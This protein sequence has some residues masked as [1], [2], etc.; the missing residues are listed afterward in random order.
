[1]NLDS[2]TPPPQGGWRRYL[3]L[4]IYGLVKYLPTP[5]GDLLRWAVAKPFLRRLDTHWIHEGVTFHNPE[6]IS[7]G[8]S[9]LNEFVFING[10]GGVTIGDRCLIGQR[11]TFFSAEHGFSGL[12]PIWDQPIAQR[13]IVVEDD[14]YVG[15]GAVVLGGVRVGRGA[16]LAAGC[17]VTRDVPEFAIMAGVPARQIGNR[18]EGPA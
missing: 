15:V 18:R 1:M 4:T 5:L 11:A 6:N 3:F 16:V 7:I 12:E 10:W 2:Q 8:R 14:V 17:V 9:A 13:P